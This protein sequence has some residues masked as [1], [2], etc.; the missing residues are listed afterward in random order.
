MKNSATGTIVSTAIGKTHGT[1]VS[2]RQPKI[3]LSW[4]GVI[5]DLHAGY[6]R[7][8]DA[9]A[10]YYPRGTAMRNERQV[11]L[12]SEEDLEA[13]AH[14]LEI[15]L[16][17]PEWL[18]SNLMVRGIPD[19]SYLLPTTRLVF[20]SGAVL[21]VM[22][23]NFPCSQVRDTVQGEYPHLPHIASSFIKLA[24][25]RRGLI[26]CVEVPG[27]ISASDEMQV[28]V[29]RNWGWLKRLAPAG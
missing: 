7:K 11:T 27:D 23:E 22:N 28:E 10:P 18:G 1:W 19:F 21:V 8:A 25:H 5:G 3:S 17:E 16:I 26:A 13:A 20:P 29:P 14:D 2:T 6:Q 24:M 12:V 15:P 4:E 9:R